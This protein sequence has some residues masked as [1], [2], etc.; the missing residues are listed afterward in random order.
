MKSVYAGSVLT[1]AV[2]DAE[3]SDE[4]F[5]GSRSPLRYQSCR[6]DSDDSTTLLAEHWTKWCQFSQNVPGSTALD[7]RGWVLQERLLSPR[8]VYYGRHGLHWECRQGT[9]CEN[10]PSFKTQSIDGNGHSGYDNLKKVYLEFQE[11]P[12]VRSYKLGDRRPV[13]MLWNTV[14][15]TYSKASLSQQDD[16]L[17]ALAGV[18]RCFQPRLSMEA[19]FGV[20]AP[21]AQVTHLYCSVCSN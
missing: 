8:T 15:T 2:A 18:A 11:S 9:V 4:G 19:S 14:V 1:I 16:K 17:A 20:S 13:L 10:N 12:L 7:Q 3:N 6:L 5:L 21:D